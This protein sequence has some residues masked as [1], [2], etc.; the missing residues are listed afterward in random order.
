V[1]TEAYHR[2][3]ISGTAVDPEEFQRRVEA[4]VAAA[5][6]DHRDWSRRMLMD[7]NQKGQTTKLKEVVER[8][9][10]TGQAILAASPRL[11]RAAPVSSCRLQGD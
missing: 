3:R 10:A 2:A 9:G 5:P 7:R 8:S 4:V 6:D 11:I 1:A